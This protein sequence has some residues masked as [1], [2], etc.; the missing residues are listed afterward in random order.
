VHLHLLLHQLCHPLHTPRALTCRSS[1]LQYDVVAAMARQGEFLRHVL[2]ACYSEEP[3]LQVGGPQLLA[4]ELWSVQ[5]VRSW[6]LH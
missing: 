4:R 5:E 3:F 2:R 6:R 1:G